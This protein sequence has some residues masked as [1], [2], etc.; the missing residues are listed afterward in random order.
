MRFIK[1]ASFFLLG[2]II[3]SC[4][5]TPKGTNLTGTISDAANMSIYFD[6]L[7][8]DNTNEIM[9]S[10]KSNSEGDFSFNFPEGIRPGLYRVRAGAKSADLIVNGT[11]NAIHVKGDLKSFGDL[12]YTVT[13]APLTEKYLEVIKSFVNKEL[14][15]KGLTDKTSNE[16]DP[17]I[18]F[19]ISTKM[20]RMQPQFLEVHKAV[21][22]KLSEKYPDDNLALSFKGQV[23]QVERQNAAQMATQKIQVGAPAPEI[24]LPGVD[25]KIRK[26]SDL[27]GKVVLLDFW[28]SWCGPCRKAN[29]HVVEVYQKYKAQG[30][31]VFSVSLDGLDSRTKQ[32]MG[33]E[34]QIKMQMDRS[35]ERWLAAIEKDKLTWDAHVSDLKKWESEPA[36]VYGVRSIPK[37]F[38]IGRDGNIVFVDPRFNLEEQVKKFL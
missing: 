8:P 5:G 12:T 25:G 33:S 32:R 22:M 31:D 2:L 24:A 20:L 27:K 29:P 28:A 34:D 16:L 6:K 3:C 21:S 35:K 36:A 11:E 4:A 38:L 19:M 37:T 15:L 14:D 17:L 13:G 10:G 18:G 26:L 7:G 30:F 9:M 23:A 1:F